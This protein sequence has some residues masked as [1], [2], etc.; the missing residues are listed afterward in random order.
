MHKSIVSLR[1]SL[2]EFGNNPIRLDNKQLVY[3]IKK[4][5]ARYHF[6]QKIENIIPR[7]DKKQFKKTKSELNFLL[8]IYI[9]ED[10]KRNNK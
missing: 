7:E 8:Q 5:T 3:S 2:K 10:W 1:E 6:T 9:A 4:L